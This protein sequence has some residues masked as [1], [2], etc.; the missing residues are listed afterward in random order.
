MRG[1]WISHTERPLI[2]KQT[3]PK[4]RNRI[5]KQNKRQAREALRGAILTTLGVLWMP[6]WKKET[7]IH[8]ERLDGQKEPRKVER[9]NGDH[10]ALLRNKEETDDPDFSHNPERAYTSIMHGLDALLWSRRFLAILIVSFILVTVLGYLGTKVNTEISHV[11][12]LIIIFSSAVAV[13]SGISFIISGRQER[14]YQI[15]EASNF[16]GHTWKVK[17]QEYITA[18][19][20][21]VAIKVLLENDTEA[22]ELLNAKTLPD[23]VKAATILQSIF[24]KHFADVGVPYVDTF[25]TN[26]QTSPDQAR[27][28][29]AHFNLMAS[30]VPYMG[31]TEHPGRVR[32]RAYEEARRRIRAA[33]DAAEGGDAPTEVLNLLRFPEQGDRRTHRTARDAPLGDP[34][35]PKA[36]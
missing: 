19:F 32:A 7:S 22:Q 35:P 27:K 36:A 13:L 30:L 18:G 28:A 23:Q 16:V 4:E 11:L 15:S 24:N 8:L 9:A 1:R 26:T 31:Y 12:G 3:W 5:V 6:Q 17:R 33:A 34:E 25:E 20:I 29:E 21:E 10:V 2:Y 14:S